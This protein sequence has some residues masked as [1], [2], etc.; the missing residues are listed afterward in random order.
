MPLT[1][2]QFT[3]DTSHCPILLGRDVHYAGHPSG[4]CRVYV[5]RPD[6]WDTVGFKDAP[7]IVCLH[8][9]YGHNPGDN[10]SGPTR[11][12]G[13][14]G[15]LCALLHARGW[16]VISLDYPPA[17]SNEN[18]NRELLGQ[19]YAFEQYLTVCRGLAWLKSVARPLETDLT[20]V[21]LAQATLHADLFG[22]DGS[23]RVNT[24][25]PALIG[26]GGRSHGGTLA[27]F[28]AWFPTAV[29]RHYLAP[30]ALSMDYFEVRATHKPAFA[31]SSIG[32]AYWTG[33][34]V[35]AGST[36]PLGTIFQGGVQ[37]QFQRKA[38]NDKWSETPMWHKAAASPLCYLDQAYPENRSVPVWASW[39]RV[40]SN[41]GQNLSPTFDDLYTVLDNV[42]GNAAFWDPHN[43]V[44]QA[45]MTERRVLE[46]GLGDPRSRIIWGNATNN[47][48]GVNVDSL[49]ES[50]TAQAADAAAWLFNLF[51]V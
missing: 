27:M 9:G 38:S 41:N 19:A 29:M 48:N 11:F 46:R 40:N 33:Y 24:L 26:V 51:G 18:V 8:P 1:A 4:L 49:G 39:G 21:A 3:W 31:I 22:V 6:G 13:L 14:W 45:P 50:D 5:W 20:K 47:P 15:E 37:Q 10:A 36:H 12:G 30:A 42:A 7:A 23:G 44:P 35:D 25:N 34:H 16:V 2:A 32:Q 17:P 28:A 43:P